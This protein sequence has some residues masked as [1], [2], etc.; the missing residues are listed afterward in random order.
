M[1]VFSTMTKSSVMSLLLAALRHI[2]VGGGGRQQGYR[3][4]NVAQRGI[5]EL[6]LPILAAKWNYG[7][8]R[9]R[10]QRI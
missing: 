3:G 4:K 10:F 9:R 1:R 7:K 5:F 2:M 6:F 8:I